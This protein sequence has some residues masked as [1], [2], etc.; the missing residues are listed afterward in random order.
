MPIVQFHLVADHYPDSAIAA[1][2]EEASTFYVD[3]L[4]PTLDPRPIERV[5]AFVSPVPAE[6]FATGGRLVSLGGT[7]APYFTCLSLE[8]RPVEQLQALLAGFTD[9]IERH[10]RCDRATIR[11]TVVEIAPAFWSIGGV[12]ASQA[13]DTE[14]ALRAGISV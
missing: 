9:L 14:K 8:G 12:P 6:H 4:Y 7:A 5:R 2:L 1:L 3:T 13:R 10:L 11:G